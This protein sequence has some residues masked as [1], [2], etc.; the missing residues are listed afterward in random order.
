[1]ASFVQLLANY[2]GLIYV[3]CAVVIALYLREIVVARG[4]R[5]QALYS[6][7][8][9][10]AGTRMARGT[11]MIGVFMA[12][13]LGTYLL[14]TYIAPEMQAALAAATP[15]P[16]FVLN[17]KTPTATFQ[18]TPTRTPRATATPTGEAPPTQVIAQTV[19]APTPT[20]PPLLISNCPDPNA[21]LTAPIAGQTFNGPI[22]LRGTAD[23]P[24]F[25][26]YKFTL[27][28][29]ATGG[30]EVTAGDVVREPRRETVLGEL[31]ATTLLA[32]PGDYVVGLVVVDNTGNE[33][34]HCTVSIIV[35]PAP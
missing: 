17:T 34:P 4:D 2:A 28:G 8:R 25:A 33:L 22:Q 35:Q 18:P 12:L 1:M 29:P 11:L 16:Q 6:L 13:A 5:K 10:A 9:E 21:Q 7:E 19:E 32:Q 30:L 15:T 26:F 3:A 24:N 27:R 31:D 14:A 20:S 23:A